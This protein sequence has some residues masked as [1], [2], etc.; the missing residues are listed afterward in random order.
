MDIHEPI[1]PKVN[2]TNN[3]GQILTQSGDGP[4]CQDVITTMFKVQNRRRRIFEIQ[5]FRTVNERK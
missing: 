5:G 2:T 4:E 1:I 3:C